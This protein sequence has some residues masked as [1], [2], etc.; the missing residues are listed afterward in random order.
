MH[1]GFRKIVAKIKLE[2]VLSHVSA[3]EIQNCILFLKGTASAA[4]FQSSNFLSIIRRIYYE[5]EE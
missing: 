4:I 5:R 1:E 2:K 3:P